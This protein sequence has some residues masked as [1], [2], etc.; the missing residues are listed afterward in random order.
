[1]RR[2]RIGALLL[3]AAACAESPLAPLDHDILSD[4]ALGRTIHRDLSAPI[5]TDSL[6]HHLTWTGG[7]LFST[8]IPFRY[9]ND[10]GRRISIVNC[11]GGLKVWLEKRVETE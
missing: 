9:R 1:M 5:Q 8:D 7:V 3:A 10:T 4:E 11:G 6:V 2:F